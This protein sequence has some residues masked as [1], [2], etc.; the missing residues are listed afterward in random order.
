ME[1]DEQKLPA[2]RTLQD[3]L[4]AALD[5]DTGNSDPS[6]AAKVV[7][8]SEEILRALKNSDGHARCV[9]LRHRERILGGPAKSRFGDVDVT[10]M[11]DDDNDVRFVG[12]D[13]IPGNHSSVDGSRVEG[14]GDD[15]SVRVSIDSTNSA[16]I[17]AAANTGHRGSSVRNT[18]ALERMADA[19]KDLTESATTAGAS[20][21]SIARRFEGREQSRM[22]SDKLTIRKAR[23]DAIKWL[24]ENEVITREEFLSKVKAL[25]DP[26]IHA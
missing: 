21:Q 15:I 7:R 14:G 13:V 3:A 20:M 23:L 26:D 6:G 9:M 10:N 22:E 1:Y 25:T 11:Q 19:M 4:R 18:A 8:Q 16:P 5:P 24:H 17:T 12:D 2:E